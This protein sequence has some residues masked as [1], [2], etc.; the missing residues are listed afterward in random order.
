[1]AAGLDAVVVVV[2]LDSRPL[3]IKETDSEALASQYALEKTASNLRV[4]EDSIASPSC[5]RLD[6]SKPFEVKVSASLEGPAV[7][8]LLLEPRSPFEIKLVIVGEKRV[9]RVG[10]WIK[11]RTGCRDRRVRHTEIVTRL[12]RPFHSGF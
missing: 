4:S 10:I 3:L 11:P 12:S 7:V 1:M 9:R 2:R 6:P 8:L 5:C